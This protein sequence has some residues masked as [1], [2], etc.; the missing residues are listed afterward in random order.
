MKRT[1]IIATILTRSALGLAE[2][3]TLSERA[4]RD[5]AASVERATKEADETVVNATKNAWSSTKAYITQDPA[6]F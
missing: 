2:D 5:A 4:S 1:L 3:K 6:E